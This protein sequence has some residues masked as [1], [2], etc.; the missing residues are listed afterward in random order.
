MSGLIKP[1]VV[2]MK[3][4]KKSYRGVTVL[5]SVDFE[6]K[7]G[8][9]HIIAGDK[10]AGKTTFLKVLSGTETMDSGKIKVFGRDA[11][12]TSP[13]KAEKLGISVIYNECD[14]IEDLSIAENIFLGKEPLRTVLGLIG[15]VSASPQEGIEREPILA[16]KRFERFPVAWRSGRSGRQDDTPMRRGKAGIAGEVRMCWLPVRHL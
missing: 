6:L 13:W 9:V 4:I 8:E 10:G 5:D 1:T 12:I 15:A 11:E 2:E 14:L 16:A 3:G 7:A